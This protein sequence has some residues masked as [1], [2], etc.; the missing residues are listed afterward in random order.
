MDSDVRVI[1]LGLLGVVLIAMP[2]IAPPAP[3]LEH[4]SGMSVRSTNASELAAQSYGIYHY[5]NLSDRAQQ[6]YRET[7]RNGG[8][9][10]V[11]LGEGASEFQ[12]LDRE[13]L[14]AYEDEPLGGTAE[15]VVVIIR[16]NDSSLPPAD[17]GLGQ[18]RYDAMT[19]REIEPAVGSGA[20]VPQFAALLVGVNVLCLSSYLLVGRSNQESS[21]VERNG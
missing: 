8:E 16:P 14:N 10:R 1:G 15:T 11:P 20:Y 21:Q 7:L 18:K 4:D 5:E 19:T 13:A 6:I 9:H 17:E 2:V 3:V 12:Y